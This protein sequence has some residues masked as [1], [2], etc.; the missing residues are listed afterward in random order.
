M[1]Y[2]IIF[3]G[4]IGALIG[5]TITSTVSYFIFRK[6]L[7]AQSNRFFM[8]KLLVSLQKIH[9]A[10]LSGLLIE[11]EMMNEIT[12]F[13]LIRFKETNALNKVLDELK[14]ACI[15]YNTGHKQSLSSTITSQ[16]EILAKD[17]IDKHLASI[18]TQVHSLT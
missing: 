7:R 10:Q 13:Q 12:A 1:D 9:L 11:D 5:S 16:A 14:Q 2:H 8:E 6:Q 3:S 17:K 15:D 18:M 4:L